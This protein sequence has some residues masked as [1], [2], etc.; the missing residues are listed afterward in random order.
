MQCLFRAW[1]LPN[2]NCSFVVA[3]AQVQLIVGALLVGD[4]LIYIASAVVDRGSALQGL[5]EQL[6]STLTFRLGLGHDNKAS[7]Q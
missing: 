2:W 4:Q 6:V 1:T 7:H 3:R 5:L